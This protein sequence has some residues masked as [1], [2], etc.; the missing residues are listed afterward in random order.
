MTSI[1]RYVILLGFGGVALSVVAGY[2][3]YIL[4]LQNKA[5]ER[6]VLFSQ[7]NEAVQAL[8]STQEAL[9]AK[10]E[11]F[12]RS[13]NNERK[14]NEKFEEELRKIRSAPDSDDGPLAPVLR[15]ALERLRLD[16]QA[17]AQD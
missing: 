9:R 13:L 12:K 5:A 17:S 11:A 10:D 7:R 6:D 14:I 2:F 15:D 3:A 1:L 8:K 4:P 16:Q